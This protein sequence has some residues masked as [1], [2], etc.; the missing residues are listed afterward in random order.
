MPHSEPG[1]AEADAGFAHHGD[2]FELLPGGH[3]TQPGD[4]RG[5]QRFV[6]V[7]GA[8]GHG[9]WVIGRGELRKSCTARRGDAGS[10][11]MKK[12]ERIE[13]LV[14]ALPTGDTEW[15]PCYAGWFRCF[16]AGD[17]FEAHD[18]LEHLWLETE[19]H[20]HA[21]FKGLIQLAGAFVHLKKQHARPL[22]P[23]DGKRLAPAARLFAL[24]VAHIEPRAPYHM[25]L[26]VAAVCRLARKSRD[27]ILRGEYRINPWR[28]DALPVIL[29]DER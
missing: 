3:F 2:D 25:G 4:L 29:L 21:F 26:D 20:D 22:H 24:A 8:R 27:A 17:Y 12:G 15:H 9:V 19:G 13:A 23:K 6:G 1:D 16:N 11:A 28:P 5:V 14:A 10:P 18:V 7:V